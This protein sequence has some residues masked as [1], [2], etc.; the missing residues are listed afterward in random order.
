VKNNIGVPNCR[1]INEPFEYYI[2][3]LDLNTGE[4]VVFARL[5]M[6]IVVRYLFVVF[7]GIIWNLRVLHEDIVVLYLLCFKQGNG[8]EWIDSDSGVSSMKA[9]KQERRL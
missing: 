9:S 7:Y 5:I 6:P 3:D 8:R 1:N 4:M 2:F